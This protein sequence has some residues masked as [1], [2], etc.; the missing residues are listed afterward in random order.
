MTRRIPAGEPG[1][2]RGGRG[3]DDNKSLPPVSDHQQ[4]FFGVPR[5]RGHINRA[6][7]TLV[8]DPATSRAAAE[9]VSLESVT[10]LQRAILNVLT[11]ARKPCTD[12]EICE[13]L[14]WMRVSESGIRSRR[15]ELLRAGR[16]EVVDSKGLTKHGRPCRRYVVRAERGAA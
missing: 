5:A 16:I 4:E 3:R 11:L 7:G 14:S 13:R 12:E 10:A 2:S 15:S 9:S 6:D 8:A 1:F